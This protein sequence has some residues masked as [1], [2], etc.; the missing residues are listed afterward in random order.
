MDESWTDLA[1]QSLKIRRLE[2][3]EGRWWG[4][5]MSRERQ[6]PGTQRWPLR[7]EGPIDRQDLDQPLTAEEVDAAISELNGGAPV[8][9]VQHM[10]QRNNN[11]GRT[12]DLRRW[13][14]PRSAT[15]GAKR[16]LPREDPHSLPR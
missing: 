12:G 3:P 15:C 2:R 1:G 10:W 9:R 5:G 6:G 14:P 4:P 11:A 13:T 8:F 7:D 16:V